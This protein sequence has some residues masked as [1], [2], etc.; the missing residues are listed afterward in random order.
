MNVIES[1]L[2]LSGIPNGLREPLLNEFRKLLRNYA[3]MRWEP[4]ELNGGKLCEVVYTVIKGRIDGSFPPKPSKP[5]NLVDA[6]RALERNANAP[7]SLRLQIPRLLVALYEVR[8]GRNVG[9]VGGDVDPS[10]MDANLV[11]SV[12]QWL[13]AE[14]VRIF[15]NVTTQEASAAV[16]SLIERRIPLLWQIGHRTRVLNASMSYRD[17]AFVI[18]YGANSPI[19][20]KDLVANVEYSNASVFRKKVLQPAHK[21]ALV[22]FDKATDEVRLSPLGIRYVEENIALVI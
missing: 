15:H 3:E 9:H 17:K 18:L 7:R 13:M 12:A 14:L 4:A 11:V 10:H 16:E 6:C 5:R 22:D 1:R 8:N 21:A 20:A 2:I 19:K